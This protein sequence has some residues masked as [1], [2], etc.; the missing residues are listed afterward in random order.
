MS[1][2]AQEEVRKLSERV[3][4]GLKKAIKDGRVLGN[5]LIYGYKKKNGK[6]IIDPMEKE[7][8]T[9]IYELYVFEDIG[10][11]RLSSK[12]YNL[13]YTSH[14]N[15]PLSPT[16]VKRIIMNPKYKGYYCGNKTAIVD[17]KSKKKINLK[18]TEWFL[19]QDLN[20]I[21]PIISEELWDKANEKLKLRSTSF[22]NKT[23]DKTIFH[24][25]YLYSGKIYCCHH[26]TYHRSAS[27]TRINNPTWECA[28]YRKYGN[29]GCDN[30][31]L[32]EYKLD[33]L[34]RPLLLKKIDYNYLVTT[35]NDIYIKYY[36]NN[37]SSSNIERELK[38]I[39]SKQERLL[40]LFLEGSITHEEYIVKKESLENSYQIIEKKIFIDKENKDYQSHI[41]LIRNNLNEIMI[42]YLRR[43]GR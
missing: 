35:L 40:E 31:K 32:S 19:Y 9:K 3:R 42:S 26:Q 17:Y 11:Q 21:P 12:L 7:I 8:I 13:G 22:K 43:I 14:L 4:F 2:I 1:S 27:G 24:N 25:R 20:N 29:K 41:T 37:K 5:S 39:I 30:I 28:Y 16:V 18:E 10:L 6:L 33:S 38:I 36:E 15:K 34:I 23:V